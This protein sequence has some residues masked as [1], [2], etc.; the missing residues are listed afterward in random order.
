ML[1]VT[2]RSTAESLGRSRL[3]R[4]KLGMAQAATQTIGQ[5]SGQAPLPLS[6]FLLGVAIA[7]VWGTNFVVMKLGLAYLPPL[8]FAG[9]RFLFVFFPAAL[10]IR[11]PAVPWRDLVAYGLFIGVG[12]FGLLFLALNGHITPGLASLVAQSQVFFTI[13]LSMIIRRERML[14]FQYVALALAV[15]GLAVIAVKGGGSASRL[16]LTMVLCGGFCWGCGNTV[17]RRSPGADM[18]AYIVWSALF[19]APPLLLMALVFEGWP[20]IRDGVLHADLTTWAAVA[21]QS[22]GNSL[23]GFAAWAWLLNRHPAGVVAPMSLLVPIFGI[24]A[25]AIVLGEGLEPWKLAAAA[26]V[27]GGLAFNLLWPK[28]QAQLA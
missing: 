24:G 26:L 8:L 21:W 5:P 12:Q 3:R 6:H 20:A 22:L 10:F 13:A 7:A 2:V 23:F 17:A 4:Y 11:K 19:S 16:G 14:R 28:F 27:L 9:L 1:R 18:L 15:S 25:S